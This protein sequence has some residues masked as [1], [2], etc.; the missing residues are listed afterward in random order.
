MSPITATVTVTA[1]PSTISYEMIA[2]AVMIETTTMTTMMMI[3]VIETM[4]T[5]TTTTTTTMMIMVIET[6]TAMNAP[7]LSALL[8]TVTDVL[9]HRTLIRYRVSAESLTL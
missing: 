1:K 6:T 9:L 4:M 3:M 7:L 8:M 5:T 2:M